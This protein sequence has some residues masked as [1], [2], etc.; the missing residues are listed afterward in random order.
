VRIGEIAVATIPKSLPGVQ[1]TDLGSFRVIEVH[2]RVDYAGHYYNTFTGITARAE[3]LPDHHIVTP[4]ASSELATVIDNADP[5]HQGRVKVRFLW[6]SQD[7]GTNWIRVQT[8]DAGGSDATVKNRGIV[9][10]SEIGDQVIVGFLQDDPSRP[11][12]MGS[13]FHRDNSSGAADNNS[14]KTISTR[15]GHVIEFNDDEKGDWGISIKDK[16]GN[17]IHINTKDKKLE[18]S[19][20]EEVSVNSKKITLNATETLKLIA[21]KISEHGKEHEVMTEGTYKAEA[22]NQKLISNNYTQSSMKG[23]EILSGK[24]VDIKGS[25]INMDMG[26]GAQSPKA[27]TE[28]RSMATIVSTPQST[29]ENEMLPEQDNVESPGLNPQ[30]V[31]IKMFDGHGNE[32]EYLS[33]ATNVEVETKDMAGKKVELKLKNSETGEDVHLGD[34]FVPTNEYV[35]KTTAN[36]REH[37]VVKE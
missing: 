26:G 31:S 6:Q 2:H 33:R 19:A 32:T 13:L 27:P 4:R 8:P 20:I 10:I 34:Y 37:H 17:V 15:S 22:N 14:V 3:T 16:N 25:A 7:E 18:L 29:L 5:R 30:I 1:F 12:V 28:A 23:T 21:N 36:K 11:Y 9:F 35:I 24:S